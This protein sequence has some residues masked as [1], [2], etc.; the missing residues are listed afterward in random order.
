[1]KRFI[2]QL[3]KGGKAAPESSPLQKLMSLLLD[4]S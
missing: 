2:D 3:E 4:M 1:M